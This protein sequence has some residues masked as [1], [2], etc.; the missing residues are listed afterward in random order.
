LIPHHRRKGHGRALKL[1]RERLGYS[2]ARLAR[3]FS[4]KARTISTATVWQW[5]SGRVALPE[6]VMFAYIPLARRADL[7]AIAKV[8]GSAEAPFTRRPPR[9]KED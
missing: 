6:L 3:K 1:I 9:P 5:E 4:T 7:G 2:Q 8:L